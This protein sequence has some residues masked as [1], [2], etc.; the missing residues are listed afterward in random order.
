MPFL[1]FLAPAAAATA[2][3]CELQ[4]P[5]RLARIFFGKVPR[6]PRTFGGCRRHGTRQVVAAAPAGCDECMRPE[7]RSRGRGRVISLTS[8]SQNDTARRSSARKSGKKSDV[9]LCDVVSVI[10]N[11]LLLAVSG[12]PIRAFFFFIST[13][14]LAWHCERWHVWDETGKRGVKRRLL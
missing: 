11:N 6:F 2:A 10:T 14:A 3:A 13:L 7:E 4:L 8:A 9:H 1:R 5:F 12:G